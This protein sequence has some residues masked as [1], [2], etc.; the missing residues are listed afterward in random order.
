[1]YAKIEVLNQ[2]IRK[3]YARDGQADIVA[4]RSNVFNQK[5]YQRVDWIIGRLRAKTKDVNQGIRKLSPFI[6]F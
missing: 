1:M 3:I 2:K 4:Y 6:L 5:E